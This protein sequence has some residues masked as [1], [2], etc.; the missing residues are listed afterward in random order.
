MI[1]PKLN[2]TK[3]ICRLPNNSGSKWARYFP[4]SAASS[5][6]IR[7]EFLSAEKL[8][9][10]GIKNGKVIGIT[11][12]LAQ[13]MLSFSMMYQVNSETVLHLQSTVYIS[14]Q[15]FFISGFHFA[16]YSS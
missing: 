8:R 7:N 3:F 13:E 6:A 2:P 14:L 15:N 9:I 4:T 5:K 16:N 11:I 10:R 1:V 12:L